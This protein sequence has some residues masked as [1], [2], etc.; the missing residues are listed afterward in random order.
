MSPIPI[1]FLRAERVLFP[2]RVVVDGGRDRQK[3]LG[4]WRYWRLKGGGGEKQRR[5]LERVIV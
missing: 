1:P 3:K 5:L 4:V 2:R